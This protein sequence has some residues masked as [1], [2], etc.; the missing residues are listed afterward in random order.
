[1]IRAVL[2]LAVAPILMAPPVVAA[3]AAPRGQITY[4]YA[5]YPEIDGLFGEQ[6]G[7]PTHARQQTPA[8]DSSSTVWARWPTTRIRRRTRTSR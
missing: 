4:T 2:L 7:G 8:L 5:T 6:A 1:M 3:P